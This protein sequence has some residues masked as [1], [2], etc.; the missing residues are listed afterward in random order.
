L[1]LINL[2]ELIENL[3]IFPGSI[4]RISP[5]PGPEALPFFVPE[6]NLSIDSPS[7]INPVLIILGAG[8]DK[9]RESKVARIKIN[10]TIV[11]IRMEKIL[12]KLIG[13]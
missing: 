6:G 8:Q 7:Q 5:F 11:R 12:L 13:K 9:F 4:I 2:P 10:A 3:K 1:I